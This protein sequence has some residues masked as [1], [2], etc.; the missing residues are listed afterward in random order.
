MRSG[1][2]SFVSLELNMDMGAR[3]FDKGGKRLSGSCSP[4]QSINAYGEYGWSYY[5]TV[6]ASGSLRHQTC[7]SNEK[8]G[9]ES[10]K[11]GISR[12][13]MPTSNALVWETALLL[14][15]ARIGNQSSNRDAF[16]V[17]AG[18]HFHPRPDP[19][20]LDLPVDPLQAY[21]DV[22]AA[23]KTWFDNSPTE[24]S[25]YLRYTLPL[26]ASDL[27]LGIGGWSATAGLDYSQTLGNTRNTTPFAID[28]NDVFRRLNASVSIRHALGRDENLSIGLQTS[29]SGKNTS[30]SSAINISYEKTYLK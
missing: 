16:G 6:Y 24:G 12:R 9:L 13:V 4:G 3:I 1:G 28:S 23:V 11:I 15:S 21:W 18:L 2:E 14:P 26:R 30:D 19:Y 8:T 20:N 27:N 7:G 25:V 5:T 22:G 17:Q 10:G 29:L